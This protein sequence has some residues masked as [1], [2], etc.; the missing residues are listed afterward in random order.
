MQVRCL[1][2]ERQSGPIK[3]GL[4]NGN[5]CIPS[6]FYSLS[7]CSMKRKSFIH[8]RNI[9]TATSISM[10][11]CTAGQKL[12][13]RQ[14]PVRQQRACVDLTLRE[15]GKGVGVLQGRPRVHV[16]PRLGPMLC[17]REVPSRRPPNST[18]VCKL[19]YEGAGK[20]LGMATDGVNRKP[21]GVADD[22]PTFP[23][24][25]VGFRIPCAVTPGVPA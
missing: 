1:R 10:D 14:Q 24:A 8:L 12:C 11:L 19:V 25:R 2:T 22:D 17:L 5:L 9:V 23:I 4:Y 7:S 13:W 3:F 15:V 20:V 16:V 18:M 21:P 6:Q